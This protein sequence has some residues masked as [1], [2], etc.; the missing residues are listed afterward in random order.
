MGCGVDLTSQGNVWE[1]DF[2]SFD[3]VSEPFSDCHPRLV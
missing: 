2:L 3:F 1:L